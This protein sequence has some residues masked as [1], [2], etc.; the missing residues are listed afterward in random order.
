MGDSLT[1][2]HCVGWSFAGFCLLTLVY[3]KLTVLIKQPN[4][5][6]KF[7]F[8]NAKEVKFC[9]MVFPIKIRM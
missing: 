8:F 4:S 2:L 9:K 7:C 5:N 3:S 6:Q 1:K